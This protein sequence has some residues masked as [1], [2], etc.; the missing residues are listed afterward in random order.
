MKITVLIENTTESELLCEHGLSVLIENNGK[1][2]LLD[3]GTTDK[4]LENARNMNI[5]MSDVDM[6]VLS[7]GHYDHSG[8]FYTYLQTN[9]K[10]SVYA[11]EKFDEEYFSSNGGMHE[12]GVPKDII[13]DFG[14]RFIKVSEVTKIDEGVYLVPHTTFELEKIGERT[15]L[16]KKVNDEIVADDFAHELSL[17]IDNGGEL[18]IFNSCSHGGFCNI[19][20]EVK[21][22]FGDRTINAFI[23]GLH[24]KGMKD[25]VE[26]CTFSQEQ[27]DEIAVTME[28]EKVKKI[29]TGHCTGEVGFEKV[30]LACGIDR[31]EKLYTGKIIYED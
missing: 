14:Q 30:R 28:K 19:I 4:F 15:G 13:K 26:Y 10:V 22:Y 6:C 21:E 29:Y 11:M 5:D 24:M 23:G 16:F 1:K 8:G 12:I 27:I 20:R 7:H 3:A 25:G 31:V 2:Y 17:V 18:T 9:S